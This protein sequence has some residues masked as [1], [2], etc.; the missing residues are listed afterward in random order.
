[1][2]KE[3][4]QHA[5][6][7]H[8]AVVVALLL[9]VPAWEGGQPVRGKKFAQC[10]MLFARIAGL[11]A[12]TQRHR[13]SKVSRLVQ[14]MLGGGSVAEEQGSRP[15]PMY[16]AMLCSR[17]D[18]NAALVPVQVPWKKL[19]ME[20]HNKERTPQEEQLRVNKAIKK[21]RQRQQKIKEVRRRREEGRERRTVQQFL[22]DGLHVQVRLVWT[23]VCLLTGLV[24]HLSLVMCRRE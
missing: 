24:D 12:S 3:Q 11:T 22:F 1:M 21:D 6:C 7:S 4:R 10:D 17:A 14:G 8:G 15:L 13:G 20:R 5:C 19:E 23:A 9:A 16:S 2:S 18:L